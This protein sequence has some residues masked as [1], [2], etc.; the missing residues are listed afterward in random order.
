MW[1]Q[2][3]LFRMERKKYNH[4]KHGMILK[5][6]FYDQG[7]GG[8]SLERLPLPVWSFMGLFCIFSPDIY[9]ML[10]V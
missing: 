2:Y 9:N 7:R 5:R 10:P 1:P 4:V 3:I 6:P 8:R